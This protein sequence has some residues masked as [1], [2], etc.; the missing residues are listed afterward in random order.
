MRFATASRCSAATACLLLVV[1]CSALIDASALTDG[2]REGAGGG[3]G[4][5]GGAHSAAGGGLGGSTE[6]A[7]FPAMAGAGSGGSTA[8]S[9][10]AGESTGGAASVGGGATGGSG[11]TGGLEDTSGA[12]GEAGAGGCQPNGA[13]EYCDGLD[14][15]CD[16]STSDECPSGCVGQA[17]LG[18]GYM[19][20]S[21][22]LNFASCEA[23]CEEQDMRLV[24]IDN[25][26]ENAF[27]VSRVKGFS[28]YTWIGGSDQAKA[29]TFKWR[30][31]TVIYENGVPAKGVYQNFGSGEPASN[32]A[33]NCLQITKGPAPPAGFW[34][35]ATCS[36]TQPYVC[37]RY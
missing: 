20:C 18:V 3:A 22:E 19:A 16:P 5:R 1:G 34:S 31:G 25:A 14:N 8:G 30:D 33:P 24:K 7:G 13:P 28:L 21:T 23:K 36:D 29:G 10:S 6:S 9:G 27:V 15:D 2:D 26:A 12:A 11:G 17:Y 35:T 32:P 37:E 4:D